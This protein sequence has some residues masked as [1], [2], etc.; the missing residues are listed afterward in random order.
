M[1]ILEG[2]DIGLGW[3][4]MVVLCCNGLEGY[5]AMQCVSTQGVP[6]WVGMLKG[7]RIV[8]CITAS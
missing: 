3:L 2:Q 5:I 4:A 1:S 8:S 7:L 6:G